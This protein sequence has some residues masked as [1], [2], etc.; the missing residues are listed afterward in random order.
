MKYY[1]I[2]F[3][4]E[5]KKILVIGGGNAALL[6]LKSI[7][8]TSAQITVIAQDISEEIKELKSLY[9]NLILIEDNFHI[10]KINTQ[11]HM[12]FICTNNSKL[13]IEICEYFK[14]KKTIVMIADNKEKSD[15][16]TSAILQKENITVSVNT[17]GKSP[18]ASKL[19][20]NEVEKLL[21]KDFTEKINFIC[22]I[23]E[24]LIKEK[25]NDSN[26]NLKQKMDNV[27]LK[28]NAE[29]AELINEIMDNRN[30]GD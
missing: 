1:P 26:I 27:I 19:V 13:N 23:R 3:N 20:L 11:Y 9:K 17:Q 21:T 7:L 22:Q 2:C 10:N 24:L 18:T 12:A 4:T 29:L 16:I 30:T 8:N 6:K 28:S 25:N 15:F 14:D 5:N